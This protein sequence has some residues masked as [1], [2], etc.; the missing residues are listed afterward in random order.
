MAQVPKQVGRKEYSGEE[1]Q[2]IP[3]RGKF[4]GGAP[5]DVHRIMLP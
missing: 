4:G 2:V 3:D 5:A 1:I